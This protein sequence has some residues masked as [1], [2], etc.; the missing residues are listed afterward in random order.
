MALALVLLIGLYSLS[1]VLLWAIVG[2]PHL[3]A[4]GFGVVGLVHLLFSDRLARRGLDANVVSREAYP[5]LYHRI[6]RL[7]SRINLPA[8]RIAVVDS[9]VPNSFA[10]GSTAG[11]AVIC[12]TTELLAVLTEEELEAVLAHELA[13]VK[14][15]DA[16][17]MSALSFLATVAFLVGT[18]SW[19]FGGGS[20]GRRRNRKRNRNSKHKPNRDPN[21]NRNRDRQDVQ[22]GDSHRDS[23][24][25]PNVQGG[26][27]IF[28]GSLLTLPLWLVSF[29]LIRA[30]SR[31]REFAADRGG[32]ILTGNPSALASALVVID[33]TITSTPTEDLRDQ[34]EMNAFFIVPVKQGIIG[35]LARTHPPTE[36]RVQRLNQLETELEG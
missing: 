26:V 32:A 29:V 18:W 24:A 10:T 33:E 28:G 35:R 9:A 4:F 15:R 23:S 13:H 5:D 31:Y 34:A 25:G 20:R 11:S 1:F 19:G 12:V 27:F 6:D 22:L 21:R 30:L 14:N 16:A 8:P 3:L 17:V 7:A 2:N 36:V